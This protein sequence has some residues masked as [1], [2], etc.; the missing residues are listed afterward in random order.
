LDQ[1]AVWLFCS[2]PIV[3]FIP[4]NLRADKLYLNDNLCLSLGQIRRDRKITIPLII[5]QVST[6]R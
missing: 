3:E 1:I 5:A 6:R 4:V 2:H